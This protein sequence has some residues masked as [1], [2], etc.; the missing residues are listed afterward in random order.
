MLGKPCGVEIFGGVWAG[1]AAALIGM[2]GQ[3][4]RDRWCERSCACVPVYA[5]HAEA[6]A[7]VRPVC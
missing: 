6:D 3:L 1:N 5:A 7:D 2:A 4:G